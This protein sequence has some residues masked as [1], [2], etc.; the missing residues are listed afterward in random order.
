MSEGQTSTIEKI[1]KLLILAA[2][3]PESE[4]AKTAS[5]LAGKIMA[6]HGIDMEQIDLGKK[7]SEVG[8]SN[9]DLINKPDN[10]W[11]EILAVWSAELFDCQLILVK[12]ARRISTDET[13]HRYIFVGKS[14][15][16][17]LV[18]WFFKYLR[19]R[20][21]KKGSDAYKEPK[22]KREFCYGATLAVCERIKNIIE[23]KKQNIE[24]ADVGSAL[25]VQKDKEIED[26]LNTN[27]DLV[28]SKRKQFEPKNRDPYLEGKRL[29]ENIPLNSPINDNGLEF[30][31]ETF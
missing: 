1:K 9:Y 12:N 3:D 2:S 15:D 13:F 16:L 14:H 11:V 6:K 20:I 5:V 23:N 30:L 4:E 31:E 18:L 25:M 8:T 21:S 7:K 17:E 19:L 24:K 28:K 26:F 27:F 29:G 10:V 22:L